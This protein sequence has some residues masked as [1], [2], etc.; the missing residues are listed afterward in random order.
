VNNN[1]YIVYDPATLVNTPATLPFTV[2][3]P[4]PNGDSYVTLV[5]TGRYQVSFGQ[6]TNQ[7]CNWGISINGAAPE[8]RYTITLGDAD[9]PCPAFV[10]IIDSPVPNARLR[11]RNVSGA[12]VTVRVLRPAPSNGISAYLNVTKIA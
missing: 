4:G 6:F 2:A 5:N 9:D 1:T 12:N 10:A 3:A 11:I 7:G 8:A